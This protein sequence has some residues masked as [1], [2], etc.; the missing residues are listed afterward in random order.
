MQ[1]TTEDYLFR[2]QARSCG[3][4]LTVLVG[5]EWG[6]EGKG[7]VESAL[8]PLHRACV[9]VAGGANTGR[10]RY[11]LGSDGKMHKQVF[12]LVPTGWADHMLSIIGDWVLLDLQRLIEEIAEVVSIIGEPKGQLLISKK[13]PVLMKYHLLLE[14][15][16][17]FCR[18]AFS[19]K[20]TGRGISSMIAGIDLRLGLQAGHLAHPDLVRRY[21][22]IMYDALIP[23]LKE[24]LSRG[25]ITPEDCPSPDAETERLLTLGRG[26]R[27]YVTDT[28][29]FLHELATNNV[30]TLFGLTQGSALHFT[31]TY[32]N[33]SATHSIAQS[34]AYCSGLPMRAFGPIIM[35]SKLL[36]TRVGAGQFP[37]HWWDRDAAE[38]F[39]KDRPELF[40]E[41]EA[42]QPDVRDQFLAEKRALINSGQATTV[43]MAQ[44]FMVLGNELGA[45]TKRGREI[46]G[47]DL[48]ETKWACAL[49]GVDSL[50]LTR[51]DMLSGLKFTLPVCLNYSIDGRPVSPV[52]Y[53]KPSEL[54][55]QV[56][57]KGIELPI[58][59]T[60][61]DLTGM[62]QYEELPDCVQSLVGAYE[63]HLNVPVSLSLSAGFDGKIFR[64]FD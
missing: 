38:Q 60:G 17:E 50:V 27:D 32:P 5:D 48:H 41:L 62:G 54:L 12:H 3:R 53:P 25:L 39:P 51:V 8:L 45:T 13:A 56:E 63:R 47:P 15:W 23:I 58:D 26:V 24:M 46:G 34:V 43:D 11:I 61:I 1:Y 35:A 22:G 59:L 40:S 14:Q 55:D 36:P 57:C 18:G 6:D 30:P 7:V 2:L 10:T 33:N 19:A 64:L 29:V 49:N 42:C 28:D 9:R 52:V 16:I 37:T 31:G 4:K 21:V 44:Y 20:P